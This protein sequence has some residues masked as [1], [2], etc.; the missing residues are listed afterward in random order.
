MYY[1]A[2]GKIEF[3]QMLRQLD[4]HVLEIDGVIPT[5]LGVVLSPA[6]GLMTFCLNPG[7]SA[8]QIKETNPH[9]FQFP[10]VLESYETPFLSQLKHEY[11]ND[12]ELICSDKTSVK[13]WDGDAEF[14]RP[15]MLEVSKWLEEYYS[16][17]TLFRP[18]WLV[19]VDIDG[20]NHMKWCLGKLSKAIFTDP[21]QW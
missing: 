16:V 21:A 14:T 7:D 15:V 12:G 3:V 8:Q 11:F 2:E 10:H 19:I 4:K 20:C 18:I 9:D 1:L 17:N 13:N 6:S 5:T